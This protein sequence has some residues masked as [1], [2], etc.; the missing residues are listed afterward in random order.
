MTHPD[1]PSPSTV[2]VPRR[3]TEVRDGQHV[4]RTLAEWRDVEAYVLL[5]EPGAGK[6]ESLRAEARASDGV[7]VSARDFITLGIK[8]EEAGKILFIDGLDEM[9]A[10]SADG[11]VPLDQI[12][13]RLQSLGSPPFRLSCREYDWRSQTDRHALIRV[14]RGG[15]LAEL[16]LEPLSRDEQLHLLQARGHEVGDADAFMRQAEQH[17]LSELLGNPLLLDL[18]VRAVAPGGKW[19]GSRKQIYEAA[20]SQL[21]QEHSEAHR[22]TRPI[23]TGE[24]NRLLN[25]AGL[26]CAVLLLSGKSALTLSPVSA[27]SDISLPALPDDLG[28]GNVESV[29]ASKVFVTDRGLSTPRHRSIAE[30]LAAR[31]MAA[32]LQGGLPVSRVAALM[33]GFDGGIVEPLKGLLGWLAVHDVDHRAS[34]IRLD[35]MAVV[36]NGDVSA[37]SADEKRV[38]LEALRDEATRNPWL[39]SGS[40]VSYPFA[41]LAVPDMT[42]VLADI[43]SNH[44]P[45]RAH[46]ALVDCV[47][48]ALQ[49]GAVLPELRHLL[50][51]WVEDAEA[52]FGNRLGALAAWAHCTGVVPSVAIAWLE[53][54]RQGQLADREGRLVSQLLLMLYPAH[55]GASDV[56]KYWPQPGTLGKTGA[57]PWFWRHELV[58]RTRPD[59]AGELADA[60][61]RLRQEGNE[62][63]HDF[64]RSRVQGEILLLALRCK[65]DAVTDERL[66]AWL[67]ICTDEYGFSSIERDGPGNPIAD[68][69]SARPERMKALVAVGW[70]SAAVH[71]QDEPRRYLWGLVRLHGATLPRDWLYWLMQQ[72]AETQEEDLAKYCIGSV[73]HEVVRPGVGFD[74]PPM[75]ELEAW[76]DAHSNQWPA[77]KDWLQKAWTS[78]LESTQ[79]A[80]RSSKRRKHEADR[81]AARDARRHRLVPYLSALT[82]ADAK[83]LI[84]NELVGAYLARFDD[85]HGATPELRVQ[86]FLVS[87]EATARRAIANLS[88]VLKRPDLPSADKV[89][90][91]DA[92]GKYHLL[93]PAGLVAAQLAF[94]RDPTV[95]D[96]WPDDLLATL[97]AFW[98]TYGVGDTPT[99][100]RHAVAQR[101]EVIAPCFTSHV[102]ARLRRKGALFVTGLWAL[103]REDDHARLAR[104]VLPDLLKA[105]PVRASEPARGELNRSLLGALHRLD[106]KVAAGLIRDRLDL[107]GLD[108]VQR[109]CWLVADL[110]YRSE[111]VEQLIRLV[112]TN[113]RRRVALGTALHEQGRLGEALRDVAPTIL[114]SLIELLAPITRPER[115]D[116]GG[117]VGAD[118][119]RGDT[120]RELIGLLAGDARPEAARELTRLSTQPRLAPWRDYFDFG[121]VQQRG[122][123]REAHYVHP[124]PHAVINTLANKRP[125]NQAD[126]MALV[127]ACLRELE[128]E[129]RGGDTSAWRVFWTTA[130]NGQPAPHGEDYCRDRLLERLRPLLQAH[131]VQG[132]PERRAANEKRVDIRADIP[133]Q[134][135][136][137]ALPI[138]IK[139]EDHPK[140]WLA[141]RD[142]LQAL[143]TTDPAAAGYGLYLAFWFDH[144][145]R[146][147][148]EGYRP[149][150]ARDFEQRLVERIPPADRARLQ[151]VVL[152][153]SWPVSVKG[154]TG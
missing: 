33:Q 19:P 150:S 84:L 122:V 136:A 6:T 42:D 18:A 97:A 65:G 144:R 119:R 114:A 129:F 143:Y 105:F 154:K 61:L 21:G 20:C 58:R 52:Q 127:M 106:D 59:D 62:A 113:E 40:W 98:L 146:T 121:A 79:L 137:I 44:S 35:P 43:L 13:A 22:E 117:W 67:G 64:E 153:L 88:R 120:V 71:T 38:L 118:E 31:S 69:L 48:D 29:L 128:G 112:G 134:Q 53:Q 140:V 55:V 25:V 75:E 123:A 14:T 80:E 72:A 95:V 2:L 73:A 63:R 56:L 17:G 24:V 141:W 133:G 116:G 77:A 46:Q 32:R 135:K 66:L 86:D 91:L 139:K 51:A 103:A 104:L 126:L 60:W 149:Q 57:L 49:H 100:Y 78:S 1:S 74:V 151:V 115:P 124:H 27:A 99:W 145:P 26:L 83:P 23:T 45:E 50:E 12:R 10:G 28:L 108:P 15:H 152:D 110:R 109:I 93:Q 138:E 34:W 7:F 82:S 90:R 76:V 4:T 92:Q 87:D 68:W 11:R 30:Y 37:L 47:L 8:P 147:S 89:L 125:A 132:V 85:I 16:H 107:A 36:I 131:G 81:M 54:A 70:R 41:P 102:R 101:P 148:P 142:Q 130:A 111:A 3:A 5:G 96:A 9:R 94:D 39:R